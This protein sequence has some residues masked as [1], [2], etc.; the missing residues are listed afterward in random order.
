[1]LLEMGLSRAEEIRIPSRESSRCKDTEA[2][3]SLGNCCR[4][5]K[6]EFWIQVT[7]LSLSSYIA[8]SKFSELFQ[9]LSS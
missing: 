9:P 1:M 8:F 2:R 4:R 7:S 5:K 3:D 6:S